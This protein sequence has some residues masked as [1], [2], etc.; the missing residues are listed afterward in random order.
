MSEH[1]PNASPARRPDVSRPLLAVVV[2]ASILQAAAPVVP[3]A[4]GG[5]QPNE[6]TTDLLITP[7]G[8]TFSL[9]GL[10]YALSIVTAVAMLWKRSTGT[11]QPMRL[12]ID[13][14][15]AFV[16]AAVWIGVSAAEW[17]WVTSVVLTVMTVA[18]LDAARIAATT[19]DHGAPTWLTVLTRSTVG[20]Y[21]AWATAAVFQ[22]WAS[23]IGASFGDPGE[24]WWQIAVLILAV[25]IGTAVTAL[26]GAQLP[27]YPVTLV[28]ALVGIIVTAWGETATVVG[29]CIAGIVVVLAALGWSLAHDR[30]GSSSWR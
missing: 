1:S 21:A 11:G 9:W 13:L 19:A 27:L 23:D 2:L 5:A 4:G 16:G 28:W 7:A 17:P 22:N 6:S 24:Q 25:L 12:S 20:I 10:I 3:Y 15:V 18:L 29:T 8:Y 14:L 26:Y 30:R